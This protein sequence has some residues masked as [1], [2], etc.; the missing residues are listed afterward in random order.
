LVLGEVGLSGELHCLGQLELRLREASKLGFSRALAPRMPGTRVM[1]SDGME[2]I[3]VRTLREACNV[4]G[5]TGK[6]MSDE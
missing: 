3:S 1:E 5:L 2:V 4:L 6:V